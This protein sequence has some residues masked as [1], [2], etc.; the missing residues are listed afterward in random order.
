MPTYIYETVPEDS[1]T[2]PRRFEVEQRMSDEP[3][4]TD[5]ESGLPVRRVITGG[6]GLMSAGFAESSAPACDA[7]MPGGCPG[8]M[9]GLN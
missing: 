9:C 3:L 7:P 6:L 1:A 5:P 8:G 4:K 2:P